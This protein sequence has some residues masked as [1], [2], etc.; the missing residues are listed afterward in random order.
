MQFI[1][2][3]RIGNIYDILKIGSTK[4]PKNRLSNYKTTYYSETNEKLKYLKLYRVK[5]CCYD[6]D[7]QLKADKQRGFPRCLETGLT[8]VGTELYDI[9]D[10]TAL[11]QWFDKNNITWEEWDIN[12]C[13]LKSYQEYLGELMEKEKRNKF[14]LTLKNFQIEVYD[15]MVKYLEKN[16]RGSLDIFC[17]GGK[18]ILYQKYIYDHFNKYSF[19]ILV[20]PSLNLLE[21]MSKRWNF[22]R[23]IGLDLLE[24]GSHYSG[25]TNTAL[26]NNF[27]IKGKGFI[28]T[29]YDS[30]PLLID[31][32]ISNQ[33]KNI[34]FIFDECHK[35]CPN[36]INAS[37]LHQFQERLTFGVDRNVKNI[38]FGTATPKYS[39]DETSIS[40]DK[41]KYFGEIICNI[42]MFRLIKEQFLCNYKIVI[43]EGNFIK[44]LEKFI[45][46]E[47]TINKILIYTN[48]ISHVDAIFD[49]FKKNKFFDDINMCKA[50]SKMKNEEMLLNK[51]NFIQSQNISIMINCRLFTEGINIPELDCVVFCDPKNSITEIIQCFGRA[52]RYDSKNP[53]KIAKIFIPV[54]GD[55]SGMM[56]I[57][58]VI[59]T[60]DPKLREEITCTLGKSY[61][62]KKN[63]PD[64]TPILK[65]LDF[66]GNYE[67][68]TNRLKSCVIGTLKEA[69]LYVLR[70]QVPRTSKKIWQEIYDRE[71]W[72]SP[73]GKTPNATCS[74][75]C[76]TLFRKGGLQ[77]KKYNNGFKYS[78]IK[79]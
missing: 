27:L 19:I 9:D 62:G 8:N 13:E 41:E 42:P 61:N 14:S 63:K 67:I 34:L 76:G 71:L 35:C 51:N 55:Y 20:I 18:T 74:A 75:G 30:C 47:K 39:S 26:I 28:I 4:C 52:L 1:Y 44:S 73:A 49:E 5:Q 6:I 22:I 40:M 66:S 43:H 72:K 70:D 38:I 23:Q 15:K 79:N 68:M 77:R 78:L 53:D 21:D 54:H 29:T 2:I 25:T 37:I 12:D 16:I 45:T 59:S 3:I 50:H 58:S 36:R 33:I 56:K 60:Q 10:L 69:I 65:F 32:I 46:T 11:E 17:G 48:R 31:P 57:I 7:E 24:I 64:S